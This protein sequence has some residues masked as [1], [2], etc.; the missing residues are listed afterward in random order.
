MMDH[1]LEYMKESKNPYVEAGLGV[2]HKLLK[3][4]IK[5]WV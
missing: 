4:K 1:D 2:H 3:D 5:G